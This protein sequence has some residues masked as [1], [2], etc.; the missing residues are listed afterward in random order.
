MLTWYSK[1]VGQKFANEFAMDLLYTELLSGDNLMI[2]LIEK[3]L[4]F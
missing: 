1:K 3:L 4:I 2:G